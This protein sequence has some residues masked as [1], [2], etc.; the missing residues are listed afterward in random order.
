MRLFGLMDRDFSDGFEVEVPRVAFVQGLVNL[1]ENARE[2]QAEAGC[3]APIEVRVSQ[4][5]FLG[6][7]VVVVHLL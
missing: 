4:A 1:L 5:D 2:A 6:E 3:F 7:V